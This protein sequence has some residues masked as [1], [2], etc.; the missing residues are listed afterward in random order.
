[1]E[2]NKTGSV[3]ISEISQDA[4]DAILLDSAVELT[5]LIEIAQKNSHRPEILNYVLNH[6]KTPAQARKFIAQILKVNVPAVIENEDVPPFE[7]DWSEER[8][9]QSLFQTIQKLRVGEKILLA[10]RGSREIRNLLLRDT[11][12]E[13][14][15]TVLE[16]PK[17]T[18]SEI[19]LLAKQR[20]TPDDI[21]RKIANKRE[22]LKNYAILHSLVTNPKTPTSISIRLI[23]GLKIKDLSII[24]KNRNIPEPVRAVVKRKILRDKKM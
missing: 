6:P 21:L 22:W 11:S 4:I 13:V 7:D 19:E 18:E 23:T 2:E 16:N 15:M 12:K 9:A 24:E 20:T 8:R 3:D 17:I 5:H 14:V 10:L 1:V